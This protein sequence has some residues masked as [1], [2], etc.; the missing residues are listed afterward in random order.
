MVA[1]TSDRAD[2]DFEQA[3]EQIR[4]TFTDADE[5]ERELRW[6]KSWADSIEVD[7]DDE[8][9]AILFRKDGSEYAF[10]LGDNQ[11]DCDDPRSELLA[12]ALDRVDVAEA[13]ARRR[14]EDMQLMADELAALKGGAP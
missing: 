3:L 9:S 5:V 6:A 11:W 8:Y 13:A 4:R 1:A 10:L 12:A 14:L 2:I 7:W